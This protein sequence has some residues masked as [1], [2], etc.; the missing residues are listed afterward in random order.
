MKISIITVVYNGTTYIK[1]CIESVISQTYKNIEYIVI[2]GNSTDG[3]QLIIEQYQK[4]IARYV[5]EKDSGLYDALNKGISLATG[6]IIG[7]LNAD[8]LFATENVVAQ[9]A[10]IFAK[11]PSIEAVYGNLNYIHPFNKNVIRQW[12]I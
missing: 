1:D 7:I 5:S 3:T 4:Q 11:N 6:D 2:D 12:K 9:I 10:T 8:D